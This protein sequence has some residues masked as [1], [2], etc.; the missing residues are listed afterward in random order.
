[1]KV[2]EEKNCK[3]SP[4]AFMVETPVRKLR[5]G[6]A[7]SNSAC[8]KGRQ[9][10]MY[11]AN[12]SSQENSAWEKAIN[13]VLN[14]GSSSKPVSNVSAC[15]RGRWGIS[16][17]G[18][19]FAGAAGAVAEAGGPGHGREQQQQQCAPERRQVQRRS[20]RGARRQPGGPS[21]VLQGHLGL[22]A[23]AGH[24]DVRVLESVVQHG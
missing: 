23:G 18:L 1:M 19:V 6:F 7:V 10:L 3:K 4:F 11:P 20:A 24:A 15:S 9:Y 5:L 21:H 8:Q 22:F 2:R 17:H 16:S 14:P 13:N 12:K